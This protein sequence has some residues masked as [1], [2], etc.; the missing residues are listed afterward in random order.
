MRRKGSAG[1]GRAY[2]GGVVGKEGSVGQGVA[3]IDRG[4]SD[5]ITSYIPR[6]LLGRIAVTTNAP[7]LPHNPAAST[8]PHSHARGITTLPQTPKHSSML[9]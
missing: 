3:V 5:A 4:R 2:R 9:K 1:K 6:P 7:H 8:P